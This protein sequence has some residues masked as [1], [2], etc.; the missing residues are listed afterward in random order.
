MR[1]PVVLNWLLGR[2]AGLYPFEHSII[3]EV[4]D[5]VGGDAAVRLRS[6]LASINLVQRSPDGQPN[7]QEVNLY[8]V[9]WGKIAFDE[10]LRFTETGEEALLA[11]VKLVNRGNERNVLKLKIWLVGGRLFSLGFN[12]SPKDFFAGTKLKFVQPRIAHMKIWIDPR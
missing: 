10:N 1:V 5:R 9:R 6:Q 3:N 11:T 8:R 4:I 7:G 2:S 12:K